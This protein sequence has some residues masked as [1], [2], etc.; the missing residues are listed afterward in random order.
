MYK[1]AQALNNM[2]IQTVHVLEIS[3]RNVLFLLN[4][5]VTNLL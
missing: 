1:P 5:T 4:N 3:Q 2:N